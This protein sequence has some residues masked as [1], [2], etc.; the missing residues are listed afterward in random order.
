MGGTKKKKKKSLGRF[1]KGKREMGRANTC[2]GVAA[3]IGD[4]NRYKVRR[5]LCRT[6]HLSSIEIA[7]DEE[8][9]D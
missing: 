4:S 7:E 6:K 2:L 3:S 9:E 8:E 5:W 1:V